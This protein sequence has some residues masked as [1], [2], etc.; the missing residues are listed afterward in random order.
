MQKYITFD[1]A[2]QLLGGRSRSSLY[3]DIDKGL[4]PVPVKIGQRCY[5][6]IAELVQAV[7]TLKAK[8]RSKL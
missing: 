7:D 5:W 4:L 2:R 8:Q 3:R 1:E 6:E